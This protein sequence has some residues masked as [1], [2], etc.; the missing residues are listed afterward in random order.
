VTS[1]AQQYKETTQD[2]REYID[3]FS[4]SKISSDD[5]DINMDADNYT[6]MSVDNNTD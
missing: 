5:D 6:T 3:N 2:I 1:I 4:F